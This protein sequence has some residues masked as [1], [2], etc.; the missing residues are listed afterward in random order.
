MNALAAPNSFGDVGALQANISQQMIIQLAKLPFSAV[1]GQVSFQRTH[2][3]RRC[4]KAV[5]ANGL[6]AHAD[7]RHFN[8]SF[9]TRLHSAKK[10]CNAPSDRSLMLRSRK[11]QTLLWNHTHAFLAW[12]FSL[13]VNFHDIGRHDRNVIKRRIYNDKHITIAPQSL[14]EDG[15]RILS[16]VANRRFSH[17]VS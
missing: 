12:P 16:I 4:R 9:F 13:S 15:C 6:A 14:L 10:L 11:E 2:Q 1:A 8:S 17:A 3:A 5:V 7:R